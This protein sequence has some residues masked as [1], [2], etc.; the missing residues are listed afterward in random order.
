M[1]RTNQRR[2]LHRATRAHDHVI[3]RKPFAWSFG[4]MMLSLAVT[5]GLGG[6]MATSLSAAT[7]GASGSTSTAEVS[8]GIRSTAPAAACPWILPNVQTHESA[9][10]LAEMVLARMT[11]FEKANFVVLQNDDGYEN[12][13][14][15]VPTLC[16]PALTMQDGPNGLSAGATGVTALPSSLGIAAS[17]NLNLAYRYGQLLGQEARGKGI[18]AVQGPNLNL[19]RVLESGR[20]FEGYGEDPVLVGA[21]GVAEIDGIQ[22]EGVMA[23]ASTSPHTTKRRHGPS[24]TRESQFACSKS[25]ISRPSRR[26]SNRHMSPR[27]CAPM[28]Q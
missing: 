26:R 9:S 21:M 13:N 16:I 2:R 22:S 18:D 25:S 4:Q 11:L 10:E 7:R 19:L 5:L 14:S 28:E 6:A 3:I 24:S 15:G 17:F 23:D 8:I 27:S 1:G 12:V 20:A